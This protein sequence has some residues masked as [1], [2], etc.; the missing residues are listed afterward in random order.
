MRLKF[1]LM[2]ARMA[3]MMSAMRS[4]ADRS[5][6]SSRRPADVNA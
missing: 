6:R 1:G 4:H 2:I 3:A 5:F